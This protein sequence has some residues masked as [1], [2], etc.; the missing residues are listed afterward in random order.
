MIW[1]LTLFLF[2]ALIAAD[3]EQNTLQRFEPGAN[4]VCSGY[5]QVWGP[6][7]QNVERLPVFQEFRSSSWGA[8]G[9]ST[10][11]KTVQLVEPQMVIDVHCFSCVAWHEF[12]NAQR[13]NLVCYC[14][15][16]HYPPHPLHPPCCRCDHLDFYYRDLE[17]YEQERSRQIEAQERE[18]MRHQQQEF[19]QPFDDSMAEQFFKRIAEEA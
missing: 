2:G 6:S 17:R 9:S 13:D 12:F 4:H 8:V 19:S 15:G 16:P 7:G 1:V 18:Q 11:Q 10:T 14:N 5:E 3:D